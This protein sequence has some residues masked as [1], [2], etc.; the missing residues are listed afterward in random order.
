MVFA[1]V[2]IGITESRESNYQWYFRIVI[3]FMT[4]CVIYNQFE[5][6]DIVL[7]CFIGS[8]K[9]SQFILYKQNY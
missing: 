5:C 6:I 9:M 7:N 3:N 8:K 1:F 2:N 4:A